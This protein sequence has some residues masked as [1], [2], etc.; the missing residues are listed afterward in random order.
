MSYL[1]TKEIVYN[2]LFCIYIEKKNKNSNEH[3]KQNEKK[4]KAAK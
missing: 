1:N 2:T 4:K 3:V